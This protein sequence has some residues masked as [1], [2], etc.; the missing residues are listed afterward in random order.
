MKANQTHA[1]EVKKFFGVLLFFGGGYVMYATKGPIE[2]GIG[3]A[4]SI[5]GA[6]LL[7]GFIHDSRM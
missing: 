1:L 4:A 7:F 5:Y 6:K 3:F 2:F